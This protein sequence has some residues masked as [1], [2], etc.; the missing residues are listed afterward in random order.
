MDG[1]D[2]VDVVIHNRAR[3][4]LAKL[5][6]LGDAVHPNGGELILEMVEDIDA[7]R[8]IRM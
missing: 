7:G 5:K 2:F 4:D 6:R 1:G 8:M 3:L